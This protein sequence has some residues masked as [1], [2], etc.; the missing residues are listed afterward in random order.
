MLLAQVRV[1]D[2]TIPL[3]QYNSYYY[4]LTFHMMIIITLADIFGIT[5]GNV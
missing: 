5:S 3:V 1:F 2:N 4:V